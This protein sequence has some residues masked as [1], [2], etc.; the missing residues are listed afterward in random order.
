MVNPMW[1]SAALRGLSA[2]VVLSP[3]IWLGFTVASA[4]IVAGITAPALR[5]SSL[6]A[7]ECL[8]LAE[9]W[10]LAIAVW[11]CTVLLAAWTAP[12]L[13]ADRV[14]LLVEL[15]GS[16]LGPVRTRCRCVLTAVLGAAGLPEDQPLS[17]DQW[18][19]LT[20]L[21]AD[22][23]PRLSRAVLD[24]VSRSSEPLVAGVLA[25]Y[26]RER[27]HWLPDARYRARTSSVR[28]ALQAVVTRT[29]DCALAA[30]LVRPAARP[31][32]SDRLLRRPAASPESSGERLL[33]PS[34]APTG[35]QPRDS[36]DA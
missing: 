30:K 21:V 15:C 11:A 3:V 1:T 25:L 16:P 2:I 9:V 18:C 35:T 36:A 29:R 23:D 28:R 17:M 14:G 6:G 10:L 4:T 34:A 13:A 20:W 33:R 5:G 27:P 32:N 22:P 12:S 8:V 7:S 19:S 26:L 31:Y 24:A